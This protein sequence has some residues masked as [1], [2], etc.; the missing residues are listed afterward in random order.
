MQ[1]YSKKNMNNFSK[2]FLLLIIFFAA[3]TNQNNQNKIIVDTTLNISNIKKVKYSLPSNLEMFII[4]KNSTFKLNTDSLHS[5]QKSSQYLTSSAISLNLGIYLTD[6]IFVAVN[7]YTDIPKYLNTIEQLASKLNIYNLIDKNK[8]QI[9]ENNPSQDT[10]KYYITQL[11]FNFDA[12]VNENDLKTTEANVLIGSWIEI[13]YFIAQNQ[14]NFTNNNLY[15]LMLNQ[16]YT[17]EIIRKISLGTTEKNLN[18]QL[19]K[20]QIIIDEAL[21]IEANDFHHENQVV[22]K[23]LNK[24]KIEQITTN[25][26]EIRQYIIELY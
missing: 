26:K 11:F 4:L 16:K 15:E 24:Q 6:F 2:N 7:N 19:D 1:S 10:I 5:V 9:L 25:I 23:K 21:N 18:K 20:L 8:I 12:F 14:N 13:S 3:C 22:K 17:L